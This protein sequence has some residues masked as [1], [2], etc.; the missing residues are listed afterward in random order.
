MDYREAADRIEEH[1][2]IHFKKE[3]PHAILITQALG[4]AVKVLREKADEEAKQYAITPSVTIFYLNAEF[5]TVEEG[6]VVAIK[7]DG[8]VF[9][10]WVEFDPQHCVYFDKGSLGTAIFTEKAEAIKELHRIKNLP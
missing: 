4:L 3:Y 5:Q 8:G 7:D 2:Q 1:A 9:G 10:F 6:K